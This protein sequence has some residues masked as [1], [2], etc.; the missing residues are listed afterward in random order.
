MQLLE[1]AWEVAYSNETEKQ[2][3]KHKYLFIYLLY[4]Y[5]ISIKPKT[6]ELSLSSNCM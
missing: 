4:F 1:R 3:N 6:H 2:L 5:I